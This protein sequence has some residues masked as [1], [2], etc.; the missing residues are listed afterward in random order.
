MYTTHPANAT[1]NIPNLQPSINGA[2]PGKPAAANNAVNAASPTPRPPGVNGRTFANRA[3]KDSKHTSS[4][5]ACGSTT[6]PTTANRQASV[7]CIAIVKTAER[8][9]ALLCFRKA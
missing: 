7:T 3:N 9:S 6:R 2:A 4:T 8:A 5:G 1:A